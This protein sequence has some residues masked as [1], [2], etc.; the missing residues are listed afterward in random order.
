MESKV[1]EAK[2][3]IQ[4]IRHILIED[5]QLNLSPDEIS[6]DYSLLEGGLG[7]DSILTAELIAWIEDQFGVQFDNRVLEARLFNNL[8]L[9]ASFV[10]EEISRLGSTH[11]S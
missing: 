9:L 3:I 11:L 4:Q 6:D 1:I 7:L 8:S 2:D 10:S 5:M